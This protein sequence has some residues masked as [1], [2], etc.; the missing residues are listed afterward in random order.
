MEKRTKGGQSWG[1]LTG[2]PPSKEGDCPSRLGG[3]QGVGGGEGGKG[4]EPIESHSPNIP[5]AI[6]IGWE[7]ILRD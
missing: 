4:D 1:I 5:S 6:L 7:K 3:D 2:P